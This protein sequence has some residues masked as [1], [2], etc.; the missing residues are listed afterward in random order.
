MAAASAADARATG[1]S[2][3]PPAPGGASGSAQGGGAF[4]APGRVDL[5][6]AAL[7]TR[8]R[9]KEHSFARSWRTRTF[10]RQPV[11]AIHVTPGGERSERSDAG[12]AV[13]PWS[14]LEGG[15]S[16]EEPEAWSG[17]CVET[18][19][20]VSPRLDYRRFP[21][22]IANQGELAVERRGVS[23]LRLFYND[24][25]TTVFNLQWSWILL[26]FALTYTLSFLVFGLLW[27]AIWKGNVE[28][29]SNV[30]TAADGFQGAFQFSIE[31][32]ST[33]GYGHKSLNDEGD[34]PE[35][36]ILLLFQLVIGF[37][38]DAI[39][40]GL[41]YAKLTRPEPRSSTVLISKVAVV[42]PRRGRLVLMVR[43][44]DQQRT[45]I[46][47]PAVR[48]LL[49][50]FLPRRTPEGEDRDYRMW[51]LDVSLNE[52]ANTQLSLLMPT[53]VT[54][55]I[56]ESSPLAY[57]YLPRRGQ[58]GPLPV[59]PPTLQLVC[60]VS[61][62][63][64]ES[65]NPVTSRRS[66]LPDE[67]LVGHVFQPMLRHRYSRRLQQWVHCLDFKKFH[68]TRPLSQAAL[69][70]FYSRFLPP[71]GG[72]ALN[73]A[74]N[75]NGDTP[76]TPSGG[77]QASVLA[78][79]AV[80]LAQQRDRLTSIAEGRDGVQAS[81][82]ILDGGSGSETGSKESWD[83]DVFDVG[84]EADHNSSMR[85]SREQFMRDVM[86]ARTS[87]QQPIHGGSGASNLPSTSCLPS[88][89]SSEEDAS[90]GGRSDGELELAVRPASGGDGG[91]SG[92]GNAEQA[93]SDGEGGHRRGDQQRRRRRARNRGGSGLGV[94]R[95]A[96]A[97][98]AWY[99][100]A[101][102]TV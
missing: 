7:D 57:W 87:S 51:E 70:N 95:G 33:L 79:D 100:T 2:T 46:A 21:R 63:A 17:G 90:A 59:P 25:F 83:D 41:V 72:D 37:L 32:Q 10:D 52:G 88:A 68:D 30:P 36:T 53:I 56:D 9:L 43:L 19:A 22:L 84:A 47:E 61:G 62:I 66:L 86:H 38:M 23:K 81:R 77:K 14:D 74:G 102:F 18:D 99:Y 48:I 76:H 39:L 94:L 26:L 49:F 12:S 73:A 64:V 65:G 42:A 75:E 82:Y 78:P 101:L 67:I 20:L 8:A 58:E 34:C 40:L 80:A 29:I 97:N 60:S 1:V 92:R 35:G 55:T 96:P 85:I 4:H 28:C 44:G 6:H 50:D 27:W 45:L 3:P 89:S 31:T 54:H 5:Q 69:S 71:A 16:D 24:L 93:H 11:T 91:S 98:V 13:D 15:T